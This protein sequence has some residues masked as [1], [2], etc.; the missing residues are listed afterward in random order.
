LIIEDLLDVSRII[1]GKLRIEFKLIDMS[2]V[3][4][5]AVE[6]VRPAADAKRI[7]V[8]MVLSAGSGPILGDP[9]RLQQVVWN[10]LSNAIRF[11]PDEGF[12]Q[13]ELQ[14]VESQVELKVSDTGIGIKPEFL[15][16]IFERF[17][18][19]DSSITRAHGG[20]GMGLA[21]VKS[22]VELHGGVVAAASPGEGQGAVFTVKLPISAVRQEPKQS[23][24]TKPSL[25]KV[26]EENQELV[27]MKILVV[28]DEAD[29]CEFLRFVF[30]ECGA[31]VETAVSAVEGLKKFDS[32][33]PDIL[34]SD[35]GMPH[36]DG[37][38]LIRIIRDERQSR[39]PAVALTAMAR[40]DDRIKVLNAGY[41]MHVPKPVEPVELISIV[42]GLVGIVDRR[43][44][45]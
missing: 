2:N 35:I 1:S 39:I 7:R 10:L 41:Q 43:P 38:E 14:R 37:Y 27:G 18:Q 30:N 23:P 26:L 36:V 4:A 32:F 21:I 29:T 5:A 15:R 28:D 20:L 33:R 40:I 34:V 25:G 3:S 16:H 31:I 42:T 17:T 8:Q 19:A 24:M 45:H 11:T 6:A 12:V 44:H 22:L 13:I 9:E